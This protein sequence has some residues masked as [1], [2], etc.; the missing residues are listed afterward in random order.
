M[1][2]RTTK[3][4]LP[5]TPGCVRILAQLGMLWMPSA[6]AGLILH[7]PSVMETEECAKIAE[8]ILKNGKKAKILAKAL[9][10]AL[11]MRVRSVTGKEALEMLQEKTQTAI[12]IVSRECLEDGVEGLA[13]AM[14][15]LPP[16]ITL[17]SNRLYNRD[18]IGESLVHEMIHAY[19]YLVRKMD[20]SDCDQ[21][22]CSEI[23]ANRDG[24]CKGKWMVEY[25]RR[26]CARRNAVCATQSMFP[27][28]GRDCV[29]RMFEKCF[30][31]TV[32]FPKENDGMSG[33]DSAEGP[34]RDRKDGHAEEA[35]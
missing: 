23:R 17:C 26:R 31:D 9:E 32:P 11:N 18:D 10:E 34:P 1:N 19:D 8:E 13:R 4:T 6:A 24:E 5:Y 16:S 30:K 20:F 2:T 12:P 35:G 25:F 27:E 7:S 21:L 28:R 3:C 14:F 29:L 33:A 15:A 22:A